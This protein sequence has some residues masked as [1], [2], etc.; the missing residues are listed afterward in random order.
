MTKAVQT[1][2][3]FCQPCQ[4][5]E[6]IVT[7]DGGGGTAD[8]AG[9]SPQPQT[10]VV[11]LPMP[12]IGAAAQ[13]GTVKNSGMSCPHQESLLPTGGDA[14]SVAAQPGGGGISRSMCFALGQRSN[15]YCMWIRHRNSET[16]DVTGSC[17]PCAKRGKFRSSKYV[18]FPGFLKPELFATSQPRK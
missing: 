5:A 4:Y 3:G 11:N 1:T 13:G 14:C 9:T 17:A 10:R 18:A 12:R 6:T 16:G 15:S 2:T 7:G 8:T